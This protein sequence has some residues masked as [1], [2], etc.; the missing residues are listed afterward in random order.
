[1]PKVTLISPTGGTVTVPETDV[2]Y[3]VDQGFRPQTTGELR[4]V[5]RKSALKEE[6]GG[7]L[8]RVRTFGEG[9]MD[10]ILPISGLLSD[11]AKFRAEVNTAERGA[12]S[13]FGLGIGLASGT[14]AATFTKGIAGGLS[15]GI[16]RAG[17]KIAGKATTPKGILTRTA[18]ASGFEGGLFGIAQEVTE[19]QLTNKH[20]TAEGVASSVLSGTAFGVGVGALGGGLGAL[21]KAKEMKNVRSLANI[22]STTDDSGKVFR[23]AADDFLG[24]LDNAAVRTPR[25]TVTPQAARPMT[26][27]GAGPQPM[28]PQPKAPGSYHKEP[29]GIRRSQ[30]TLA[31]LTDEQIEHLATAKVPDVEIVAPDLKPFLQYDGAAM[32]KLS[33]KAK[34]AAMDEARAEAK[35]RRQEWIKQAKEEAEAALTQPAT[36]AKPPKTGKYERFQGPLRREQYVDVDIPYGMRKEAAGPRQLAAGP[37]EPMYGPRQQASGPVEEMFGPGIPV[38]GPLNI[39]DDAVLQAREVYKKAL[40]S[41]GIPTTDDFLKVI[42]TGQIDDVAKAV[43]AQTEYVKAVKESLKGSPERLAVMEAQEQTFIQAL[44]SRVDDITGVKGSMDQLGEFKQLMAL[45]GAEQVVDILP[46]EEALGPLGAAI[47]K[48][49]LLHKTA[50]K[51]YGLFK[52][53][54]R[55]FMGRGA[56]GAVRSYAYKKGLPPSFQFATG[57]VANQLMRTGVGKVLDKDIGTLVRVQLRSQGRIGRAMKF[58]GKGKA[59]PSVAMAAYEA[60]VNFMEPQEKAELRS[61]QSPAQKFL[62]QMKVA[63]KLQGNPDQLLKKVTDLTAGISAVNPEVGELTKQALLKK[64]GFLVDKMPVNPGTMRTLTGDRWVPNPQE[65]A[66]WARY[67]QAAI[68]PAGVVEQ[69]MQ[70]RITPEAAEALKTLDPAHFAEMQRNLLEDPEQ[71]KRMEGDFG[72]RINL[73]ILFEVTTDPTIPIYP[74]LQEHHRVLSEQAAQAGQAPQPQPTGLNRPTETQMFQQPRLNP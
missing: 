11:E 36:A 30:E 74:Q 40:G 26:K 34:K 44:G 27:P 39:A 15:G 19:A 21:A 51:G 62:V 64:W 14:G 4:Q 72:L 25:E 18:L 66:K 42:A 58:M 29:G 13:L 56:E 63:R 32:K 5:Q 52:G 1:M 53:A 33:G 70:G 69:A 28:G 10:A 54:A 8:E 12:G 50:E 57:A 45:M 61:A 43:K 23:Q 60:F 37:R 67:A 9:A 3:W 59:R 7:G 65:I 20:L 16:I 17:T 47:L 71:V 35:V 22:F 2:A 49:A 68:D 24:G 6:F 46:T 73:G 48:A 38:S 31:G 41:K 55:T